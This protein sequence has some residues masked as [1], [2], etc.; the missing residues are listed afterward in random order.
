MPAAPVLCLVTDRRRLAADAAP[1][2]PAFDP[3]VRQARWAAEAGLDLIQVRERDLE[4]GAL[5]DLAGAIVDAVRGSRTRVVVNERADVAIGVGAAGV[6]LRGD[7]FPAAAVRSLAPLIVG[8]SV[9]EPAEARSAGADYLIAGTTFATVSKAGAVR[10]LGED[11]LGAIVRSASCPVLAIG[12]ISIAR[13]AAV[14][15]AGAA[16]LAAIGLFL[17]ADGPVPL[18][19]VVAAIQRE[20]AKGAALRDRA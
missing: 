19:S 7:S 14:A 5:A 4:G 16:G 17:G 2:A 6:H 20:F 9:H 18:A 12:G 3:L 15:A 10:L 1:T 11:G 13:V 8:R